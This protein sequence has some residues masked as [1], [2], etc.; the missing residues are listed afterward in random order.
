MCCNCKY[1]VYSDLLINHIDIVF[2]FIGWRHSIHRNPRDIYTHKKI[3]KLFSDTDSAEAILSIHNLV[4]IGTTYG[5]NPGDWY[6]PSSVAF[7]LR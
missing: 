1:I 4:K 3:I 6:G 5:K 2:I 7:V